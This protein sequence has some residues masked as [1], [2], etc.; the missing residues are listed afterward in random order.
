MVHIFRSLPFIADARVRRMTC[1]FEEKTIYTWEKSTTKSE[2]IKDTTIKSFPYDKDKNSKIHKIFLFLLY[3]LWIPFSILINAKKNDI[4]VFM[5]FETIIFGYFAAKLKGTK[6]I[7]DIVDP[8]SQTKIKIKYLQKIFDRLELYYANKSDLVII[9]HKCRS[10]FYINRLNSKILNYMIIE[11]VPSFNK[12]NLQL[13]TKFRKLNKF[14]IGYFGTLDYKSRGIEWLLDFAKLFPND[15]NLII[16][17]QGAME[18]KLSQLYQDN[19]IFLGP[20]DQ[21]TLPYLYNEIDFTWAY[22]S[23][24]IDLHKYAAPNKFYEH[25][26]F[27]TPIITSDIIPQA[28]DI[29]QLNS[30]IF[31][32]VSNGDI[33]YKKEFLEKIKNFKFD[34][35]KINDYWNTRYSQYYQNKKIELYNKIK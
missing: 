8:I 22:Y 19:I 7:F 30:G 17:G 6:I 24:N 21:N 29:K 27:K 16:A 15:I 13:I 9:P 14:N 4:C 23:P 10:E 28:E 26:Y 12:Q 5:D 33:E 35:Q 32:D 1:F 18:Y 2:T 11:N 25:L 31:V 20:F 34:S 3:I